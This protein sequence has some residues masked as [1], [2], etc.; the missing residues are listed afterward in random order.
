[1]SNPIVMEVLISKRDSLLE[2]Q[3][4]MNE[5][6]NAEI[7]EIKGAIEMIS[8]KKLSEINKEIPYDDESLSYI[9]S[10]EEEI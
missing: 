8:G 9:K 2:E 4:K 10:S 1:M 6:F 5:R 3:R 7:N